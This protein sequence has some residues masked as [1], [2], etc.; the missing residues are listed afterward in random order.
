MKRLSL[1]VLSFV[2]ASTLAAG[3]VWAGDI[4]SSANGPWLGFSFGAPG[5][6]ARGCSP[7]DPGGLSCGL[8][9]NSVPA[10]TPP[11][12]FVV[13]PLGA[14]FEVVDAFSTGDVFEIFI[15]AGGPGN[16]A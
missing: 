16:L 10:D 6:P 15:L 5:V 4:S 1:G 13:G 9:G 2:A 11:W 3:L 8:M 7:A 12:T 14:T